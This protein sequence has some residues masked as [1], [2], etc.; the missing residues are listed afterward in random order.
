MQEIYDRSSGRSTGSS[1]RRSSPS[2]LTSLFL[3]RSNRRLFAQLATLSDQRR[4]L[5]QQLI[6]DARVDAARDLARAARRVRPDPDR[7]GLDARPRRTQAPEGSPLRADLREIGEIA[8][9]ALDNVRG[10]SQSLHPSILE[11]LGLDST[12][13]WYLS[14]VE[15][16]LGIDRALRARG[17]R[18]RARRHDSGIHV[19]RVLQEALNNVARIRGV[20]R[21]LGS[22]PAAN[23]DAPRARASKIMARASAPTPRGA[24]R[25]ASA[26]SGWS[27]M[28]ER[29]GLV[30]GTLE[31]AATRR[32][33]VRWCTLTRAG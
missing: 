33:A 16:Q 30:G 23:A 19:Y 14:T 29:A 27:T 5:A 2:P 17:R 6:A 22:A 21:G 24:R 31:L 1:P 3:I 13:D 25:D 8:Q 15:R 7:D 32:Q 26:G 11:E 20:Q 9:A 10:L 12:I 4:E 28:R 18:R